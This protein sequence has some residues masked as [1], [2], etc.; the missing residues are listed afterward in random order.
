V[1]SVGNVSAAGSG[2]WR[3]NS[4][5]V[6]QVAVEL[7][8]AVM[9]RT[10]RTGEQVGGLALEAL[11][12]VLLILNLL[13]TRG[14]VTFWNFAVEETVSVLSTKLLERNIS[15]VTGSEV[16]NSLMDRYVMVILASGGGDV[17]Y[18][19]LLDLCESALTLRQYWRELFQDPAFNC[20]RY[21]GRSRGFETVAVKS[22]VRTTEII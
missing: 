22:K 20:F 8:D 11:P 1:F 15:Y 18:W 17:R 3:A 9:P 13:Y 10:T 21:L 6:L 19:T 5:V 7:A 12:T 2:S 4:V 14:C 16:Y